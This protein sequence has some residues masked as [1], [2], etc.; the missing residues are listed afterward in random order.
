MTLRAWC[1]AAALLAACQGASGNSPPLTAKPAPVAVAPKPPSTDIT[2]QDY[3][4]PALPKAQVRLQDA[5]GG[6]H[7]VL[8]EV[9]FTRDQRTRGL[10]WRTSLAEGQGMIFLFADESELSFWM[11]NTLIPL[12]M[13]FVGKDLKIAGIVENAEPRTLSSRGPGRQAMYVLE[14]PGG[15]SQKIGLKPGLPVVI[16]GT[17]GLVAEP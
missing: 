12:D 7:L 5:F 9:A 16:E 13:I 8:S 10:M 14:V 11:R 4:M 1:A 2:D 17:Q 6:T 3:P 15:W